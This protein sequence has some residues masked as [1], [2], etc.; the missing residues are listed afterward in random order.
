[1]SSFRQHLLTATLITNAVTAGAVE[2]GRKKFSQQKWQM[3]PAGNVSTDI[4]GRSQLLNLTSP[5]SPNLILYMHRHTEVYACVCVCV[6]VI[7][8][9]A[10]QCQK[11]GIIQENPCSPVLH[12]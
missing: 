7:Q 5:D 11:T 12:K 2:I 10:N 1:M 3:I 4:G 8:S 6:T 9:F